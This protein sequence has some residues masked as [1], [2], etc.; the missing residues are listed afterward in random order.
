MRII[1]SSIIDA[2][3]PTAPTTDRQP[4]QY[5]IIFAIVLQTLYV[6]C[7]F[8]VILQK[9]SMLKDGQYNDACTR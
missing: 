7:N 3:P 9:I 4:I 5:N 8:L 1:N 2:N 6:Y